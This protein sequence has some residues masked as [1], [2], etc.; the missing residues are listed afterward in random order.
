MMG[1][2]SAAAAIGKIGSA[3]PPGGGAVA[4]SRPRA[5]GAAAPRGLTPARG[6]RRGVARAGREGSPRRSRRSRGDDSPSSGRK[7]RADDG[8]E[9]RNVRGARAAP[10]GGERGKVGG[11]AGGL[12]RTHVRGGLLAAL[13]LV[14]GSHG[15]GGAGGRGSAAVLCG[16]AR[17]KWRARGEEGGRFFLGERWSGDARGERGVSNRRHEIERE[18]SLEFLSAVSKR[19]NLIDRP[20]VPRPSLIKPVSSV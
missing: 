4:R 9:R 19:C 20:A 8:R 14:L 2:G 15:G 16:R 3:R 10:E 5:P 11:N 18:T 7:G 1:T 13:L 6:A 17:E 12:G